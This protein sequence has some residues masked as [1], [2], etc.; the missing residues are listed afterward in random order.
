MAVSTPH[1]LRIDSVSTMHRL[2][3]ASVSIRHRLRIDYAST[4]HRLCIDSVS[5]PY[6]V[7][8]NFVPP[9][10]RFGID[11]VSTPIN[12]L[13]IDFAVSTLYRLC[14]DSVSALSSHS[15]FENCAHHP[16]INTPTASHVGFGATNLP[17]KEIV[18][19]DSKSTKPDPYSLDF[20]QIKRRQVHPF[21]HLNEQQILR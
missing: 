7:C 13:T 14:I 4:L 20:Q 10:Y 9:P 21:Q 15:P 5:T 8:I 3:I 1:R 6:R 2:C 12:R 17:A 11:T 18:H 16:R 19:G